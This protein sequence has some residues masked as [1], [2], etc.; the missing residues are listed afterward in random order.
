[1][2]LMGL[3]IT[4]TREV[5][6]DSD[7][8]KG[9]PGATKFQIKTLDS[10]V[11]GHINDSMT[12]YA[13]NLA[14]DSATAKMSIHATA[15]RGCQF[16]LAGWKNFKNKKGVDIEFVTEPAFL[17]GQ[18]Y[19]VVSVVCLGQIPP[20]AILELWRHIRGDNELSEEEEKNSE[21]E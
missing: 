13:P 17:A 6:L 10:F 18:R 11:M 12:E 9:K 21:T 3:D 19:E 2:A 1:M 15:F 7:P 8:E 4:S 16:G 5:D 14:G 20:I